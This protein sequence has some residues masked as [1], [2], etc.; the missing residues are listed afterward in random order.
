MLSVRLAIILGVALFI[1]GIVSVAIS[2][3]RNVLNR[4]LF[5]RGGIAAILVGVIVAAGAAFWSC[6]AEVG[7][8]AQKTGKS[9]T[10]GGLTIVV[11][12]YDEEGDVVEHYERKLDVDASAERIIFDVP[13]SD[14]SKS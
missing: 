8:R 12:V 11:T 2:N 5:I 7:E 10:S 6:S 9:S 3:N 13:Q 4:K 14:G 1:G